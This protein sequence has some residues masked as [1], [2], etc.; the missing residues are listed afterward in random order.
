MTIRL[1]PALTIDPKKRWM[2]QSN[3]WFHSE[4]R[5]D[6][7]ENK[8]WIRPQNHGFPQSWIVE[9]IYYI[10]NLYSISY[11]IKLYYFIF[12]LLYYII[13]YLIISYYIFLYLIISYYI[14]LYLIISYY[15]I[16]Y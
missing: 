3:S 16:L 4:W 9:Y 5:P 13:L 15:M 6:T 14:L 10:V 11:H 1:V 2:F 12:T 7:S 8:H